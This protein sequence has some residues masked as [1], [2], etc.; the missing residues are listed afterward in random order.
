MPLVN[1]PM[2]DYTIDFLAQNNVR[3][4]YVHSH[5][6]IQVV[7]RLYYSYAGVCVLCLACR[8]AARVY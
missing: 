8:N 6:S 4:V 5:L 3:E 2:L 7:L 1:T